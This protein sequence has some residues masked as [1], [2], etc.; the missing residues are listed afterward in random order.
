MS[1]ERVE[2][3]C[4]F[5]GRFKVGDNLVFNTTLLCELVELNPTG[6]F[7]KQIVMQVGSILEAALAEV[8]WR[9]QNFNREGVPNIPEADRQEIEGK[10]VD[11]FNSVI[12]VLRRHHVLDAIGA[13]TYEELHRLRR[14]RNKIHI[15][16]DINIEGVSRDEKNAFSDAIC[17]W[18]IDLNYRV[19]RYLSDDLAR[20]SHVEG[21]V[22]PL[23]IPRRV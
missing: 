12:D 6:A 22:A 13:E 11:K 15:Q 5:V 8:I 7:N 18:A 16:D 9:A 19:I 3:P 20:P 2:V 14:F 23:T 10:R 21:Y 1:T 4:N 17:D